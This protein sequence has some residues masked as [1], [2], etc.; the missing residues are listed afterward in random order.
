MRNDRLAHAEAVTRE[1]LVRGDKPTVRA[2]HAICGGD[3]NAVHRVVA[4]IKREHQ[5]NLARDLV[6]P[7]PTDDFGD[8]PE[9]VQRVAAA[10][11]SLAV[12]R[13]GLQVMAGVQKLVAEAAAHAIAGTRAEMDAVIRTKESDIASLRRQLD[14]EQADHADTAALIPGLNQAHEAPRQSSERSRPSAPMRRRHCS[15]STPCGSRT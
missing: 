14:E 7:D 11:P 12:Q 4:A 2:V 6:R 10:N 13:V 9:L 1:M 15:P 8:L 3:Y 5:E